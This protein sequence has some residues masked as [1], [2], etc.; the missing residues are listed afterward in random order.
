VTKKC[1][2]KKTKTRLETR[3][4]FVKTYA[5]VFS[6]NVVTLLPKITFLRKDKNTDTKCRVYDDA[7]D[8]F[9]R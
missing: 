6:I 9:P 2:L 5:V 8:R 3:V 4:Q 1:D 7:V